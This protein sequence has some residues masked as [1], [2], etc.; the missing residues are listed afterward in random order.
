MSH[1]F[2][3]NNGDDSDNENDDESGEDEEVTHFVGSKNIGAAHEKNNNQDNLEQAYIALWKDKIVQVY[4]RSLLGWIKTIVMD[5]D[6]EEIGIMLVN[7]YA[8][9]LQNYTSINT[10]MAAGNIYY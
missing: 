10:L 6:L 3:V 8:L 1:A 4:I 9:L 7:N 5:L 2:D